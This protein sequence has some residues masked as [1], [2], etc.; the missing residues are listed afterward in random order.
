MEK[1][2]NT[3]FVVVV[4]EVKGTTNRQKL[5]SSNYLLVGTGWITLKFGA[6]IHGNQ[7]MNSSDLVDPLDGCINE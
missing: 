3:A 4:V 2:K 1:K 5:H 7:M 6:A